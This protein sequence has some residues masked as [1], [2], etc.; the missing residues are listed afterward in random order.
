MVSS[1]L[2]GRSLTIGI[3]ASCG[4]GFMLFGY[5]QGVFGGLL[6]N[7]SF[8]RQFNHPNATI[9]SQIVSTYTLGCIFGAILTI[10]TGDWLGRRKSVALGCAFLVVGGLL[11][12]TSFTLAHMI[13]GRIISGFG[14]GVNTTTSVYILRSIA[15]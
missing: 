13:V 5:D 3:S 12:A 7:P 1:E 10:F 15:R 14:I 4:L 9:Q 8:L 11:Q 2:T 6:S